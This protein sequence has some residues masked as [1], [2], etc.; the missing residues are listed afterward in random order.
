MAGISTSFVQVLLVCHTLT[1]AGAEPALSPDERVVRDAGIKT[2]GKELLAYLKTQTPSTAEVNRLKESVAQ[3]GSRS[4]AARERANKTLI[5]AGRASIPLLQPALASPDLEILRRAETVVAE[6]ERLANPSLLAAVLQVLAEKKPTG[7]VEAILAYAPFVTDGQVE[8]SLHK[9]LTAVGLDKGSPHPLVRAALSDG[10]PRRR[11]AAAYVLGRMTAP[12]IKEL[13]P[14]LRD[15]RAE[16]RLLAAESLIRGR[17]KSAV[18]VLIAMLDDAPLDTGRRAE[19]FLY[20]LAGE[21][22]PSIA[23]TA[24]EKARKQCRETWL[25]WWSTHHEKVDLSRFAS[26]SVP[27]GLTLYCIYDGT[28]DD[29]VVSLVGS[30]GK[31]R[32]KIGN[33]QGPNDARLLPGGR[34]LIAERNGNRVTERDGTGKV[35]WEKRLET[36]AISAERLPGGNTLIATWNQVIEVDPEGKTV[37]ECTTPGGFR[38]ASRAKN[39]RILAVSASGLVLELDRA[40]KILKTITP[41]RHAGGAGYWATV[42]QI[43]GGRIL[44]AFGTSRHIAE[45]DDTGK[46]HWEVEIPNAVFATRLPNGHTLACNFEEGQ[47]IELDRGGKEVSRQKVTGRPF[48]VRKY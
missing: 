45:L 41:E 27:L 23:L 1:F 19:E 5:D 15:S 26:S 20:H 6:I 4:F 34:V 24:G 18:P 37:W 14:L 17:E 44:V 39:G 13:L 10:E 9:A 29:G 47:V 30:D 25:G 22:A 16:V 36:G 12:P 33:L 38:H 28:A 35:L 2:E 31:E 3:L 11:G 46:I 42:E 8:E 21:T 32:W 43:A 7:S 40:G 48:A